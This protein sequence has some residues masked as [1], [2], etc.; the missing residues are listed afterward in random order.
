[1]RMCNDTVTVFNQRVDPETGGHT[2]H[3][4]T[5]RGVS[6]YASAADAVDSKGGGLVATDRVVVRVPEDVND[7]DKTYVEPLAYKCALD[8]SGLWTLQKGD[9]LVKGVVTGDNWK[10]AQLK[11]AYPYMD[12]LTVTYNRRGLAPHF[13]VVGS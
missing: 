10:P 12:V 2:Y 5:L 1:M 3:P 7:G 8:P 13:K 9:V 4:T 11:A 6:W